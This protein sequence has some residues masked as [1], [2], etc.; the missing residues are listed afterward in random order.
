MNQGRGSNLV[1]L[2]VRI[3][4]CISTWI[5]ANLVE[6]SLQPQISTVNRAAISVAPMSARISTRS[7]R[8]LVLRVPER[9]V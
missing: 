3:S 5:S 7:T 9:E 8:I 2:S 6:L 4:A 1:E